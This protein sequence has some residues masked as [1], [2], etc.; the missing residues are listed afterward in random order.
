M[1]GS[2][3]R[4]SPLRWATFGTIAVTVFLSSRP[5]QAGGF[6]PAL[7][8]PQGAFGYIHVQVDELREAPCLVL[9]SQLL[10]HVSTEASVWSTSRLGLDLTTLTD[11]T[12]I[13]PPLQQVMAEQGGE[14]AV[15]V[16]ATF[17]KS[18]RLAEFAKQLPEGWQPSNEGERYYVRGTSEALHIVS[19]TC[20][21]LG[22]PSAVKWW[23]GA[24]YEG[25][26]GALTGLLQGS[27]EAGHI[28]L[29]ADLTQVPPD[30]FAAVPP[31][32]QWLS[33]T[34]FAALDVVVDDD[35]TLA[36]YLYFN[37]EAD[38]VEA[39]GQFSELI[40]QGTQVLS[41]MENEAKP[42]L[43]DP[44]APNAKVFDSLVQLATT[45]MLASML[46]D[47]KVARDG[48]S[49]TAQLSVDNGFAWSI[50]GCVAITE[51]MAASVPLSTE[52]VS[53]EEQSQ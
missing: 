35:V 23:M 14:P 16:V 10:R 15:C 1:F 34:T 39:H 45:R 11:I 53:H 13:V 24:E 41:H 20:L 2:Y 36:G 30:A 32:A 50:V 52:R 29:G 47:I 25:E 40:S 46:E 5:S 43:T 21:V 37:Q 28:L 7:N 4:F 33:K 8:L 49:V 48:E 27:L 9:V 3:L 19:N 22:K 44:S 31:A 26:D 17:S 18:F 12:V 6:N 38:A 42:G 51:R